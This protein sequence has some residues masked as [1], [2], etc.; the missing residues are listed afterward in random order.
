MARDLEG[1][2]AL[3]TGAASGIGRAI[4]LAFAR[5]GARVGVHARDASRAADTV[6]RIQAEGGEAFAA[7]ADLRDARAVERMCKDAVRRLGGLDILVNN[8]GVYD[9]VA[10]T[11]MSEE[12]WDSILAV[13]LKAPFLVTKCCLPPMLEQG[14]GGRVIFISSTNGK[15]ANPGFSAYNASKHGLI[16]FARCLAAE[17]GDKGITVNTICP[18]WVDTKMAVDYHRRKSEEQGLEFPTLWRQSMAGTNMLK[19]LIQPEDIAECAVF[20]AGPK[21]HYITAQAINTCGGLC[22][23]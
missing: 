12:T 20:L 22:F 13:N 4:A 17:V 8:A 19:L 11:E 1:R 5:E 7:A 21:A 3:V 9:C 15:D 14:R 16:G 6:R 2:R 10:V 23:W 18:G